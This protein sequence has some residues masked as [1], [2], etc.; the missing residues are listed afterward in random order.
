LS[1]GL[2]AYVERFYATWNDNDKAGWLEN[3]RAVASGEPA[4]EDPVGTPPKRGMAMIE[5]L[6]DR[7]GKDHFKTQ[8]HQQLDCGDEIAVVCLTE[9]EH[10]G[11]S[12]TI[13]SVDVHQLR[14]DALAIRSYWEIPTGM[15]YG[16]W[17][18]A[19]GE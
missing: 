13:W 7:T 5:E 10:A 16:E 3:I 14:G 2:R 15:P 6:W 1:D 8:V 18:A 19:H 9:G 12:Y 11:R 4:I 17:T